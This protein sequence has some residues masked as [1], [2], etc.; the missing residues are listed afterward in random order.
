M[1]NP[2]STQISDLLHQASLAHHAYEQD[3]LNGEYDQQWPAWYAAW[4]L[5][6]GLAELLEKR[7]EAAGLAK[8]LEDS[9]L[10]FKDLSNQSDEQSWQDYTA[11]GLILT[12]G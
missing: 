7:P 10:A 6:N 4:L 1:D 11:A 2:K 5:D 3:E 12:Y 8:F 9:S